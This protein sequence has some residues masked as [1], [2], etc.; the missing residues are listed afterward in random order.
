MQG[1][2][3]EREGDSSGG[4][5]KTIPGDMLIVSLDQVPVVHYLNVWPE[6]EE[7]SGGWGC[8]EQ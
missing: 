1:C 6:G 3:D 7:C 8:W 5:I 2:R 4:H